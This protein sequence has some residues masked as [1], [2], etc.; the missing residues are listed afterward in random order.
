MTASGVYYAT[1]QQ[2]SAGTVASDV[3]L[4]SS[5]VHPIAT[6]PPVQG[7]TGVGVL[8]VVGPDLSSKVSSGGTAGSST[9]SATAAG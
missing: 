7:L 6:A 5:A 3:G 1:G 4:P 9:G 2:A 8:L